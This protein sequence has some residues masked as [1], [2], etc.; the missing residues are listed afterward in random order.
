MEF[1]QANRWILRWED[2]GALH[3]D[4]IEVIILSLKVNRNLNKIDEGVENP[5]ALIALLKRCFKRHTSKDLK[6]V[7]DSC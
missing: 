3:R 4:L 6:I 7:R 5:P 2:K 1:K